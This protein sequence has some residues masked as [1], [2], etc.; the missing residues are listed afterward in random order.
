M[1]TRYTRREEVLWR[2]TGDAVVLLAADGDG[3]DVFTL[4]GSGVDLWQ[5]LAEPV[6]LDEA[7][8]TLAGIYGASRD[9]VA[10]DIAPVLAELS[11]RGVIE[12]RA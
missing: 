8:S 1:T 9:Q 2:R 5:L 11:R 3:R 10:R 7:A 12:A 6:Q 4:E